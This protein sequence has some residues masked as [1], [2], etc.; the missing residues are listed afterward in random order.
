MVLDA[1]NE[2]DEEEASDASAVETSLPERTSTP[3]L[4]LCTASDGCGCFVSLLFVLL[5]SAGVLHATARARTAAMTAPT[6]PF[7]STRTAQDTP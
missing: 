3:L 6:S 1:A 2:D 4:P 7:L 5:L